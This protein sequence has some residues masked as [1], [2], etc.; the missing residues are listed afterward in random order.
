MPA[1]EAR[2][3]NPHPLRHYP[4]VLKYGSASVRGTDGAWRSTWGYMVECT[5]C[6]AVER[7]TIGSSVSYEDGPP[8]FAREHADCAHAAHAGQHDPL[9]LPSAP[10][11]A[12]RD[13][14]GAFG[15]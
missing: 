8:M 10:V 14:G 1:T 3:G 13:A 6:G 7:C 15:A 11:R 5:G 4:H 2:Y 12:L 9:E